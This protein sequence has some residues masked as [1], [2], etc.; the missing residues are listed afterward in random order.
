MLTRIVIAA[1]Y[2]LFREGLRLILES[3]PEFKI[4]AEVGDTQGAINAAR[5]VKFEI[6]LIDSALLESKTIETIRIILREYPKIRII[7]L[8]T[9]YSDERINHILENGAAGCLQKHTD[10]QTLIRFI[11]NVSLG[12]HILFTDIEET[13]PVQTSLKG[14]HPNTFKMSAREMEIL[15]HLVKGASNK[16]IGASLFISEKTVKNHLSNIYRKMAVS[17]RTQAALKAVKLNIFLPE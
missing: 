13:L 8:M 14:T 3:E 9:E 10:S 16:E 15:N 11:K 5:N 6:M 2:P 7:V 17:D 12:D 1:N 4:A